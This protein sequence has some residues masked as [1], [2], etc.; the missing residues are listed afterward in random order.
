MAAPELKPVDRPGRTGRRLLLDSFASLFDQGLLSALNLA[1]GLV[2]IRLATKEHYGLYAQLYVA[3]IFTATLL[4]SLVTG[5]LTTLAPG[6]DDERRRALL[7]HL[8][9]YQRRLAA[10]LAA[11]SGV[12]TAVVVGWLQLDAHPVLLGIAFSI[13]VWAGALREFGRSVGFIEGRAR[14]VLRMDG[15]YAVAVAVGIGA[16]AAAGAMSL[17]AVMLVLGLANLAALSLRPLDGGD[18]RLGHREA[19]AAVWAR[20]KWALP[21]ALMAWLTNYSYLY[22]A[23]LWLGLDA[24]ADLNASRLLLMPLSL[25]VLAWSRVARPHMTRLLKQREMRAL[26]RYTLL[27]VAGVELLSVVY[28]A[29]L[30]ALLPWLETHV[31]GAKYAGLEP[32]V[33][34]WTVYFALYGARSIGSSLLTSGDRY[35]MLLVSGAM[36]LVVVLV[37]TSYAVPR[38]GV[39]GAVA[40]LALVELLD[41]LLIWAV[42]LPSARRDAMRTPAEPPSASPSPATAS[43]A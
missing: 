3:G 37:A 26:D 36:C 32:L 9:R 16:L 15:W 39:W 20:G 17:P 18:G 29:L 35:R 5:P 43:G 34:A 2:L 31:L 7:G 28:G 22:L 42:L 13:Y 25:C 27:S 11:A 6:L 14:A 12:V 40:A 24:S 19:I 30:W 8:D 23:A 41:L 21:G 10:A 33:L 4:E 1:L 38:W